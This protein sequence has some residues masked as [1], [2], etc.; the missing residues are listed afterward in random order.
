MVYCTSW[1]GSQYTESL[2][3]SRCLQWLLLAEEERSTGDQ[4][5]YQRTNPPFARMGAS[6]FYRRLGPLLPKHLGGKGYHMATKEE[7]RCTIK[8]ESTIKVRCMDAVHGRGGITKAGKATGQSDGGLALQRLGVSPMVTSPS[9]AASDGLLITKVASLVVRFAWRCFVDSFIHRN[10][11]DNAVVIMLWCVRDSAEDAE[12]M[13][14]LPRRQSWLPEEGNLARLEASPSLRL[15]ALS[16][17]GPSP[18]E[19]PSARLARLG[20][21]LQAWRAWSLAIIF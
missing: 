3:S 10:G 17:R 19:K 6:S 16:R 11:N 12:P 8:V 13:C 1:R 5:V 21:P 2:S 9:S 15:G 18:R 7:A 4:L 20:E 14:A